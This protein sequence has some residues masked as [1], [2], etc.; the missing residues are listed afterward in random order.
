MSAFESQTLR[1]G[2]M[3]HKQ[4]YRFTRIGANAPLV[5][6]HIMTARIASRSIVTR[7]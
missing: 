4:T 5:R 2:G 6:S 3:H 1:G 7:V